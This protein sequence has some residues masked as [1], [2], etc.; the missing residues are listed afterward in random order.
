MEPLGTLGSSLPIGGEVN[1][2]EGM[3]SQVFLCGAAV[4]LV[5]LEHHPAMASTIAS[6]LTRTR[7]MRAA[8]RGR[9]SLCSS[10]TAVSSSRGI[11]QS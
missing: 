10:A 1:F 9:N 6:G 8:A 7:P 2:R 4:P 3:P 5:E 11:G